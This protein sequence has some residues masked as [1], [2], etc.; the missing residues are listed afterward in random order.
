LVAATKRDKK[1]I[2]AS[3]QPLVELTRHD[4][5]AVNQLILAKSG[6]DVE[7]I[8]EVANHLIS[9]GGKRLRPMITLAAAR[10]FGYDGAHHITLAM[11]VEFMHTATLL[12]DDV[13]DEGGLRRGKSTA[14][15]IWGNQASV[16][17]GDFLLGQ[18]FKMIVGIGSL[19][20]L[21]VLSNAAAIIAEGE[22][23]QLAV[24]K[25]METSEKEYLTV[26]NAKTAA[27]FSAAAEVGPIIAGRDDT[28]RS[29]L[30]NYGTSLGLAFQLA[31]DAL[32]YSGSSDNLGKNTGNDFREGKITM[33]V[34]LSYARGSQ[35]ERL[36]W[37]KA[38]EE[39]EHNDAALETA[40]MLMK[41]HRSLDDTIRQARHFGEQ[42]HRALLPL[43]AS[44]QKDA[45]IETVD[46][47]ISRIS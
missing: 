32:D 39:G 26:I 21:G 45:L 42:A 47:C 23:M 31:D 35:D 1:N 30:A 14:R 16:L 36:F 10:M 19:N 44:Q 6:S 25:R 33:P 41:K 3:I 29:A 18:A 20:C 27:L 28:T 7:M 13:V 34:I 46:F 8:P 4:M 9:S 12:H 22:V 5:L 37:K 2:Q 24:A 43:E 38:M 40:L 17:V 15:M 11:A